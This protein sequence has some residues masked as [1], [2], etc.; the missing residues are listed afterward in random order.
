MLLFLLPLLLHQGALLGGSVGDA[1]ARR[2]PNSGRIFTAQFSVACGIPLTWLLLKGLPASSW[3]G[4]ASAYGCVMFVMGLTCTWAG[5]GC[6]RCARQRE[7]QHASAAHVGA[8]CQCRRLC[9]RLMQLL[10]CMLYCCCCYPWPAAPSLLKLFRTSCA[11]R[12]TPSIGELA[13]SS[14][15]RQGCVQLL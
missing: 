7:R 11:V 15:T 4:Q 13:G 8:C 6:N 1:A 5:A 9:L 3:A 14:M 10:L 12:S 2:L